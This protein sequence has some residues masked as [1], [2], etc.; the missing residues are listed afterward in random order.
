[1]FNMTFIVLSLSKVKWQQEFTLK[2][3]YASFKSNF[4]TCKNKT[5]SCF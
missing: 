4:E 3:L 5:K 1:M 2:G